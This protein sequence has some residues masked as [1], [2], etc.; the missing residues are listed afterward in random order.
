[1]IKTTVYFYWTNF[2]QPEQAPHI[3][4]DSSNMDPP[5]EGWVLVHSAELE[6]PLPERID[7]AAQAV[8]TIDKGIEKLREEFSEKVRVLEA[9]KNKFLALTY[10]G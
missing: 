1:V 9:Q 4:P 6:V 5:P 2:L 8:A 10:E 7:L 3:Y